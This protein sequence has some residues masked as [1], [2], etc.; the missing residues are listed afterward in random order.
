MKRTNILV[1]TIVLTIIL[2]AAEIII[3]RS[4]SKH[5]P[6]ASVVL[7]A[8]KITAGEIFTED[9]LGEKEISAE[10]AHS[11]SIKNKS[12]LIGMAAK[13]D[14]EKDEVIIESRV[15]SPENAGQ[16]EIMD[17][18]N[19]LITVEFKIDQANGWQLKEGQYVD[20]IFI[21]NDKDDETAMNLITAM[22]ETMN[23]DSRELNMQKGSIVQAITKK[24]IYRIKNIRVAALIDDKGKL[25]RN[26]KNEAVPRYISFEAN[27]KLD[28]LLAYAKGNGRLE[29]SVI[30]LKE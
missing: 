26:N 3:L 25:V 27:D 23:E 30:P 4:V 9:M 11:K 12:E 29:L 18:N 6:V 5:E 19:R 21:P 24:G 15:I 22:N 2:F 14:I 7:A 20:I 1:L 13:T 16:I 17:K 10:A 28:E 8:R